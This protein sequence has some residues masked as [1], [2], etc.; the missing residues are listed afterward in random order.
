MMTSHY[1][2]PDG[3]VVS[4]ARRYTDAWRAFSAPIERVL[5]AERRA[6][7]P[8]LLL[9]TPGGTID[10][11]MQAATFVHRAAVVL[12]AICAED[13]RGAIDRLIQ[14]CPDPPRPGV[15]HTDKIAMLARWALA[16]ATRRSWPAPA[17]STRGSPC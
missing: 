3:Q 6:F 17:R 8:G 15:G 11:P 16:A 9:A 1:R 10:L 2:L 12:E 5:K 7:D 14:A 13:R 4:S